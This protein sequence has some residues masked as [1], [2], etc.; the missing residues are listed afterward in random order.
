LLEQDVQ[1]LDL[2][3]LGLKLGLLRIKL[4][5]EKRN[6]ILQHSHQFFQPMDFPSQAGVLWGVI[7][8][9]PNWGDSSLAS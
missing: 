8:G 7:T 9:V 4:M 6:F 1:L 5:L 2:L 3:I